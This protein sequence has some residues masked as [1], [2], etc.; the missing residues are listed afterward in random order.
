MLPSTRHR[1]ATRA[2]SVTSHAPNRISAPT[3][4]D[5]PCPDLLDEELHE[6]LGQPRVHKHPVANRERHVV[7]LRQL[8]RE[9][10]H[11]TTQCCT[12]CFRVDNTAR[13]R[14]SRRL[15]TL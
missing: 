5:T 14:T 15:G 8:L 6:G 12:G 2:R 13:K 1:N 11:Q 9:P 7:P 4:C 3:W 10:A